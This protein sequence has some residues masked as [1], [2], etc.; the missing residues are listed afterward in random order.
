MTSAG[1]DGGNMRLAVR[2]APEAIK[3]LLSYES[4]RSIVKQI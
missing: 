1:D 3:I 2:I 4:V